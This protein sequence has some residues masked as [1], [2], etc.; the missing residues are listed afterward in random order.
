MDKT[1]KT[2]AHMQKATC[3][4]FSTSQNRTSI[5]S[6]LTEQSSKFPFWNFLKEF[7]TPNSINFEDRIKKNS[8]GH[9]WTPFNIYCSTF[10]SGG[11]NRHPEGFICW[12]IGLDI[13]C[14][15]FWFLISVH[16][17]VSWVW[18]F[19]WGKRNDLFS[20]NQLFAFTR[21]LIGNSGQFLYS[22]FS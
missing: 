22:P 14:P 15:W 16:P 4:C 3:W 2:H 7:L 17:S 5:S 20:F 13:Y 9:W 8:N 11:I 10:H 1:N 21:I 6:K 19:R 12:G 18:N